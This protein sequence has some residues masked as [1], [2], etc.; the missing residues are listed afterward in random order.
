LEEKEKGEGCRPHGLQI[1]VPEISTREDKNGEKVQI[2]ISSSLPNIPIKAKEGGEDVLP[3]PPSLP[4]SPVPVQINIHPHSLSPAVPKAEPNQNPVSEE[5]EKEKALVPVPDYSVPKAPEPQS[6]PP[7][8]DQKETP[9]A[10]PP[11]LGGEHPITLSSP[12]LTET[13]E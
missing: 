13:K 11:D 10:L 4:D 7:K 6:E 3:P 12:H 8:T 5:K 2:N 9:A 1:T